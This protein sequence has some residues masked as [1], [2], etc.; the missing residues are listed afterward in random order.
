MHPVS[1]FP[2]FCAVWWVL[3]CQLS[4]KQLSHAQGCGS[5][6]HLRAQLQ[7]PFTPLGPLP[8]I[9]PPNLS[10]TSSLFFWSQLNIITSCL[11]V[12]WPQATFSHSHLYTILS[13]PFHWSPSAS[14]G[15]SYLFS[16]SPFCNINPRIC[17]SCLFCP[18]RLLIQCLV[19]ER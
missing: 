7:C 17:R 16:M 19:S 11:E 5:P 2:E 3:F 9:L 1:L 10:T 12:P 6:G 13:S 8:G 4:L 15:A 14:S 18:P